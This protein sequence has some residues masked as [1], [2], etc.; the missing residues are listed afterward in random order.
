[1]C[2]PR[3]L[4]LGQY[5]EYVLAAEVYLPTTQEDL[6]TIRLL[7]DVGIPVGSTTAGFTVWEFSAGG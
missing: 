5:R 6:P 3:P 4:P 7:F 1:M 2:V